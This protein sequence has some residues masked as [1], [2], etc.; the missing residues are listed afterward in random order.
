MADL[1]VLLV[2]IAPVPGGQIHQIIAIEAAKKT[3]IRNGG[4]SPKSN[5]KSKIEVGQIHRTN[6]LTIS[7]PNW[8]ATGIGV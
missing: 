2:K 6:S 8:I 7:H 4:Q 3:A 5:G 1:N